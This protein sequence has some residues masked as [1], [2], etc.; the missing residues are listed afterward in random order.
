MTKEEKIEM[1]A[2]IFDETEDKKLEKIKQLLEK[3]ETEE[4]VKETA[5]IPKFAL[6]FDMVN[7]EYRF[8]HESQ[9]ADQI[10]PLILASTIGARIS[11]AKWAAVDSEGDMYWYESEPKPISGK[12]RSAIC[13][14]DSEGN[15]YRVPCEV[16]NWKNA[17]WRIR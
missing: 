1:M 6:V 16:N 5:N 17:K 2:K 12:W 13:L 8:M 9:Y 15:L 10:A 7:G 4:T 14:S 3:L 11:N